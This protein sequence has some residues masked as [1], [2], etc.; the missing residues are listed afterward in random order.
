MSAAVAI[1]DLD[2][3]R[4]FSNPKRAE[5]LK[6]LSSR[7]MTLT[8]L[9]G[10]LGLTKATVLYHLNQLSAQGYVDVVRVKGN[11]KYWRAN[12]RSAG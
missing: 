1:P 6:L 8:E 9:A 4:L 12:H 5:I 7:E 10:E 2:T 11:R 3:A